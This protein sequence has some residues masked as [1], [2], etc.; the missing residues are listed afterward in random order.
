MKE[1]FVV[2]AEWSGYRSSQRRICHREIIGANMAVKLKKII[3]F[4]FTDGTS[5][6]LSVRP[7]KPR[8]R[9]DRILGYTRIITNAAF[10]NLEGFLDVMDSRL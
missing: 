10:H 6:S 9:V 2:E 7:A 1:R 5:L 4:R 8:E 3:G